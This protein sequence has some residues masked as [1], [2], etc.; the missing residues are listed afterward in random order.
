MPTFSID[1]RGLP[2]VQRFKWSSHKPSGHPAEKPEALTSWIISTSG[3]GS[4]LDPFMGS[5]TSLVS[6]KFSGRR[7]VGIEVDERYC[8]MA[9][10]RMGQGALFTDEAV[11]G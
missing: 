11:R 3:C 7:A 1:D 2:D 10:K 8:E 4:V 5:G 6:A 9:A